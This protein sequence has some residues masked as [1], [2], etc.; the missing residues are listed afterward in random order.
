MLKATFKKAEWVADSDIA[1]KQPYGHLWAMLTDKIKEL[2]IARAKLA[3]LEESVAAERNKELAAIPA[4]YGFESAD[5]FIA[6]LRAAM[7]KRR[8]RRPGAAKAASAKAAGGRRRKRA[9]ITDETR[10][11]VKKMVEDGKTGGEIAKAL[12]ISL[13]SVQNIKK[14]LGLTRKG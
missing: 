7:G 9:L 13:P 14:S 8:G 5:A 10:A 3:S 4:R 12:G 2:E 1:T 6:A 11:S